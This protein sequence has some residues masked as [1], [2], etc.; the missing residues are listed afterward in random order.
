MIYDKDLILFIYFEISLDYIDN[1]CC[2]NNITQY[3]GHEMNWF[4][5]HADTISVIGS[6]FLGFLWM[7]G[8]FNG[9]DK[10]LTVIKTVLIM[11]NIMPIELAKVDE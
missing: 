8:K 6:I 10:D 3:K 7:N 5:Q 9:L 1:L 11:K 2:I 4:K